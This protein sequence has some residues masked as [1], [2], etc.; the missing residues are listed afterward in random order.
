[1]FGPVGCT[2]DGP[3]TTTSS[4]FIVKVFAALSPISTR[5]TGVVPVL[6]T[7]PVTILTPSRERSHDPDVP[8][9]P[10]SSMPCHP[11]PSATPE[12]F[13]AAET[14]DFSHRTPADVMKTRITG[15]FALVRSRS[16]L[17]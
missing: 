3:D 2:T 6:A 8:T 14:S 5:P 12:L 17:T 11:V 1:M 13:W 10:H 16:G 4:K 15:P 7:Q 9:V